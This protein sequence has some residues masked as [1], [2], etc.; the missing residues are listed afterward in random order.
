MTYS[1]LCLMVTNEQKSELA[2]TGNGKADRRQRRSEE[3]RAR[4]FQTA[5]KLFARHGFTN[6]TVEQITEAADVGKGTFFNYFPTKE[7]LLVAMA[8]V[9]KDLVT[10]IAGRAQ[11]A[12]TVKPLV[13]GLAINMAQ[14]TATTQTMVRSLLG[15][16]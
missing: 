14:A 8:E 15:T 3:N 7:H 10:D 12:A 9:R 4:I 6:V 16:A 1:H 5:M 2:L 11:G 13:L